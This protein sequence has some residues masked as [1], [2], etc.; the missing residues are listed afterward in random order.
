VSD[1]KREA[2]V[3]VFVQP[4]FL[5]SVGAGT[6]L[7]RRIARH[8]VATR[9]AVRRIAQLVSRWVHV[10]VGSRAWCFLH[11]FRETSD[12]H[13]ARQGVAWSLLFTAHHR[14]PD[15]SWHCVVVWRRCVVTTSA[16]CSKS[17]RKRGG[18]GRRGSA[19][20]TLRLIFTWARIV[21]E[22]RRLGAAVERIFGCSVF[23][24]SRRVGHRKVG[25]TRRTIIHKFPPPRPKGV[26]RRDVLG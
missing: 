7:P 2:R 26:R 16:S 3:F 22:R 6:G 1:A 8:R 18:V 19:R 9:H 17:E 4:D 12:V 23:A 11:I 13:S 14:L 20:R 10:V 15:H 21:E 5:W 25:G 24:V